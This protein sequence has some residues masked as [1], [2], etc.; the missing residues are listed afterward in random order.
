MI[1]IDLIINL[2]ADRLNMVSRSS[3]SDR[4]RLAD[5]VYRGVCIT[6]VHKKKHTVRTPEHTKGAIW[7]DLYSYLLAGRAGEF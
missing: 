2:P 6:F 3:H 5:W 4:F 7:S 1:I